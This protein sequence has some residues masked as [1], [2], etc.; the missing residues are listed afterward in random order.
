MTHHWLVYL[1]CMAALIVAQAVPTAMDQHKSAVSID[2][3]AD[4]SIKDNENTALNAA[5]NTISQEVRQASQSMGQHA[6]VVA[7][8]DEQSRATLLKLRAERNSLSRA[9]NEVERTLRANMAS[10]DSI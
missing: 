7:A 2:K 9:G 6:A 4:M 10:G 5:L 1:I 3:T 8:A